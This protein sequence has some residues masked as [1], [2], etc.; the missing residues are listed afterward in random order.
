MRKKFLCAAQCSDQK[1]GNRVL[2]NFIPSRSEFCWGRQYRCIKLNALACRFSV[3]IMMDTEGSEVHTSELEQPMK[4]EVWSLLKRPEHWS[5]LQC[6]L[7]A[8]S[9]CLSSPCKH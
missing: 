9:W 4:A 2:H 5:E 1:I 8:V 3:A 7:H 6:P